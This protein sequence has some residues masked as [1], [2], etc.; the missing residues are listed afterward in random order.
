MAYDV[1]ISHSSKDREIA[2][3][4]CAHCE[5]E[6]IRCWIAPRDVLPGEKYAACIVEAIK[7]SKIM[8]VVF[9]SNSNSSIGVSNEIESATKNG[10]IIV[11]F[12]IEEVDPT[13]EMEYYL[14]SRHWLDAISPPVE[15][16]VIN[17]TNT[18]RSILVSQEENINKTIVYPKSEFFL[19]NT[20]KV[21]SLGKINGNDEIKL[22]R[23]KKIKYSEDIEEAL[24]IN[25]IAE[26][27]QVN[28]WNK[29][30][31]QF[32]L[33][34]L[35]N[36]NK[37]RSNTY[38][39][40]NNLRINMLNLDVF[41][42]NKTIVVTSPDRFVGTTT[43]INLAISM[44]DIIRKK[45]LVLECNDENPI[46]AKAFNL[47]SSDS[48]IHGLVNMIVED[49]DFHSAIYQVEG[50]HNLS[51]IPNGPKPPDESIMLKTDLMKEL[52]QK[53]RDE[54]DVVIIDVPESSNGLISS[55]MAGISDGVLL[56]VS[57]NQ[58]KVHEAKAALR[59]LKQFEGNVLGAILIKGKYKAN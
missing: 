57:S 16:H 54:F 36:C 44:A 10:L 17:L 29:N 51:I 32:D 21:D 11:P 2:F 48:Y 9:S 26:I 47:K 42:Q 7:C 53:L 49:K 40:Y 34:K 39:A 30:E 56:V 27:P 41:T 59:K 12:R 1:F 3:A 58:T 45:V 24:G 25:V 22:S 50:I 35:I 5:Q 8:I 6:K 38:K 55:I 13:N 52:L 46:F 28:P 14:S 4:I 37:E 31:S 33:K 23:W 20:S 18:I 15:Q 19:S 43:A